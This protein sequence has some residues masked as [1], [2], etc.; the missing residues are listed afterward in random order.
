MILGVK[1]LEGALQLRVADSDGGRKYDLRLKH[2][3]T[4]GDA[5]KPK[6]KL[7]GSGL[8]LWTSKRQKFPNHQL[9]LTG[10]IGVF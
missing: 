2:A 6:L 8:R 4:G 9:S 1:K 3:D 5:F 10:V 7:E